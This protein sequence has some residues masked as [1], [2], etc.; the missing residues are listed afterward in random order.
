LKNAQPFPSLARWLVA[1]AV[2]AAGAAIGAA[3]RAGPPTPDKPLQF[4]SAASAIQA[5]KAAAKA[6]DRVALHAIFGPQVQELLSTDPIQDAAE[7]ARF[8]K[9]LAQLCVPVAKG[10]DRVVLDIG[11]QD[12]PFPIPLVRKD[13]KWFFD[14]AAGKDEII[15]RRIGGDELTAIGVCRAYVS[16]QREYASQDRDGTGV[17]KFAQKLMST[18]GSRDGLYWEIAGDQDLSPFGPKATVGSRAGSP[19]RFM[20]TC[21]GFLRRRVRPPPEAPTIT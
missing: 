21:S 13:G 1:A 17:L 12:W 10:D 18:P 19:G 2:L 5:L 15:N 6:G 4:D 11:A 7:S 8:A 3:A 14:T 16:A 9:A 20:A